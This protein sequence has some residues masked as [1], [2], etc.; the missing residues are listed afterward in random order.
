MLSAEQALE[1]LKK[2]NLSY[3][4]ESSFRGRVDGTLRQELAED[5]SPY[6]VVVSCSDS[7]VLPEAIFEAGLG[8]LFTI[9]VAGNVICDHV[10]GSIQYA[11]EHLGCKL[12][13]VLGH[14]HCGAVHAALEG[15]TY[16]YAHRLISPIQQLVDEF[17]DGCMIARAHACAGARQVEE[18]FR[19]TD[20]SVQ[21]ALYDIVSGAVSWL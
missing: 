20:L 13:V 15:G 4:Q 17:S 3:Q 6:A 9:R 10:L 1:R 19:R 14:T 12:V 5:Q 21:A 2:G 8:E 7:R 11:H 18:A 16:G